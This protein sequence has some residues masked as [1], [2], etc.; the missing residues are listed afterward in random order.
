M[1]LR[2]G[3]RLPDRLGSIR[4]RRRFHH[5]RG[6]P[7]SNKILTRRRSSNSR[8]RSCSPC[9]ETCQAREPNAICIYAPWVGVAHEF[10]YI[11]R[12]HDRSNL[13]DMM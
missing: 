7:S 9:R 13:S 11:C 3:A 8:S 5:R 1:F 12:D 10:L 2:W 4:L 6:S